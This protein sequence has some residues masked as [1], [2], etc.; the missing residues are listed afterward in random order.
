MTRWLRRARAA[1]VMGATWAVPWAVVAVLLGVLVIDPDNSMDEMWVMIGAMPGF[2]GGVLFSVVLGI[3]ARRRRIEE[4]S[5]PRVAAWGAGAGFA[6]GVLPFLIGEPTGAV[7][8]LLLG[9][10][11]IGAFTLM[12]AASAAASLAVARRG[13]PRALPGA[14]ATPPAI[15]A[16]LGDSSRP[17]GGRSE[18]V[19]QPEARDAR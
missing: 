8:P 12:S 6:V 9:G 5:L 13:E 16:G 15:A 3:A 19:R 17:R 14:P 1:L 2:I 11:V 7:S 4:L 10:V 18:V